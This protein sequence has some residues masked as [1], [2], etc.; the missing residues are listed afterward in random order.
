MTTSSSTIRFQSSAQNGAGSPNAQTGPGAS[1]EK[2]DPSRAVAGA[3]RWR[4]AIAEGVGED[5]GADLDEPARLLAMLKVFGSTRRLADLCFRHP[6]YAARAL[7]E[8]PSPVL[9]EA[10][11]DLSALAT[12]VG[13]ADALHSVLAPI[14][15][16]A[17]LAIGVA[18]IAGDWATEEAAAARA[19]LAER[20][21]ETALAWL[22]RGAVSRGELNV[23][24]DDGSVDGVFALAGGDFAHEDLAPYGPVDLLIVYDLSIFEGSSA[25]MAERAFVRIGSELREALEGKPGDYPLYA[26][27]CPTGPCVNGQGLVESKA[28]VEKMLAEGQS[29]ALK[30]WI[31]ASR[32]VAGDRTAGGVFLEGAEE[33]I[34]S[35]ESLLTENARTE[36]SKEST[37]PRAPFNAVASVLR[38][39]LGR[40]RPIFRSAPNREV[41]A[42]A[43][44]AGVIDNDAADRLI[45][46]QDFAQTIVARLQMIK[47]HAAD[48]SE[49]ADE[50][51]ALAALTGFIN[52]ETLVTARD[53]IVAE[54]RNA[55]A[56]LLEGPQGEAARYRDG[57]RNPDDIDKLEDLGFRDGASLS[58]LVDGWAALC[59]SGPAQRFLR[60]PPAC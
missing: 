8:G 18:E 2:I 47:G 31:A 35:D 44:E 13:G 49:E 54:A 58:A 7:R 34:W 50:K 23:K 25:R 4:R 51:E 41:I 33:V 26:V 6:A 40:G 24:A 27:R 55:L 14:K 15:A 56:R 12:G 16:R 36:L 32:L 42:T 39:S 22:I 46:G 19:D 45:A 11:R 20:L 21:T 17:D 60:S 57:E 59:K 52:F 30:R 53:G 5:P 1:Q 37:D 3:E 38:W 28:R 10:A 29:G 43:A 48:W 9:A